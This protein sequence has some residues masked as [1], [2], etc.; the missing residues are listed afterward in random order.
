M[1]QRAP[2]MLAY[3]QDLNTPCLQK[4]H[5]I[6]V[7]NLESGPEVMQ[8]Q[9]HE[10]CRVCSICLLVCFSPVWLAKVIYLAQGPVLMLGNWGSFHLNRQVH[11]LQQF[12]Y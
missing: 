9:V 7:Q 1:Q 3:H 11:H 8:K 5:C 6:I 10:T 4:P 2:G 12:Y